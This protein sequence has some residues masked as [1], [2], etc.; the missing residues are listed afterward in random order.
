MTICWVGGSEETSVDLADA[1][2]Q[3]RTNSDSYISMSDF[4]PLNRT[5]VCVYLQT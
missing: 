1:R 2:N 5:R 3:K 4:P